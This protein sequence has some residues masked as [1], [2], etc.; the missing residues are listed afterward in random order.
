[1]HGF[2]PLYIT[3][4][5]CCSVRLHHLPWNNVMHCFRPLYISWCCFVRVHGPNL[6]RKNAMPCFLL[7]IN[8]L[9]LFLYIL[10]LFCSFISSSMK[11]NALYLASFSLHLDPVHFVHSIFGDTMRCSCFLPLNLLILFP[12]FT[13]FSMK[14]CNALIIFLG[15]C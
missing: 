13:S 15:I 11:Y 10:I 5:W 2:R 9:F 14:R 7:F 3:M 6:P 8:F 12:S 1:M 4:S